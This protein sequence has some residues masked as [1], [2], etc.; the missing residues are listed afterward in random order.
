MDDLDVMD[1]EEEKMMRSIKEHRLAAMKEEYADTQTN[2]TLGHG[3]YTE[4]EEGD[5][6]PQVTKTQ[7]VVCAF[8]HKDFERCKIMDMHIHK[9]APVHTETRFIRLDA[10]KAPFFVNKLNI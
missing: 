9:I 4:I 6:L 8:F 5:F 2:K 10:E 3:Q 1:E 7:Y